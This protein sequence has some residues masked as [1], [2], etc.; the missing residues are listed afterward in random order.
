MLDV[1]QRRT[2]GRVRQRALESL[3]R[4][5]LLAA[6]RSQPALGFLL[7]VVDGGRR[8]D[9]PRHGNL[10]S[11]KPR[12]PLS[13]GR[14]KVR[15]SCEPVGWEQAPLP[16]TGGAPVRAGGECPPGARR[17]QSRPSRKRSIAPNTNCGSSIH[18]AWPAPSIV[19]SRALGSRATQSRDAPY[20]ELRSFV[21]WIAITGAVTPA[22]S[23]RVSFRRCIDGR[24]CSNQYFMKARSFGSSQRPQLRR[25]ALAASVTN[26]GCNTCQNLRQNANG[27]REARSSCSAP[28]AEITRW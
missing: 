25:S 26:S 13:Q 1:A 11:V 22:S 19:T 20:G 9:R 18:G 2:G 7:Q 12:S 27:S 6:Q 3:A 15:V 14:K 21:P 8:R 16:R 24:R 28:I 10:P 5:V 4:A 17:C 23:S